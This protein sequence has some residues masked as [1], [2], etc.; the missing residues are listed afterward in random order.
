[1]AIFT[2]PYSYNLLPGQGNSKRLRTYLHPVYIVHSL[3]ELGESSDIIPPR[4]PT[5]FPLAPPT[6]LEPSGQHTAEDPNRRVE[7][8]G[9][10][11]K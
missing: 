7:G 4:S 6:T 10:M 8:E 9:N 1:M 3:G 5:T 2:P 11:R